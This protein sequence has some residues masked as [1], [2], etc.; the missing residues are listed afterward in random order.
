LKRAQEIE[1]GF[2]KLHEGLYVF[3]EKKVFKKVLQQV[4]LNQQMDGN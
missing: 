2:K 4:I 1:T 3:G